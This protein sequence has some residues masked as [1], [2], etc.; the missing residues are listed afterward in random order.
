[1]ETD[2]AIETTETTSRQPRTGPVS[3]ILRLLAAVLMAWLTVEWAT[4]GANGF[5][6]PSTLRNPWF[7]AIT[8]L[9]VYYGLYQTLRVGFGR[10][11]GIRAVTA[12]AAVLVA[13]AAVAIIQEGA[14]WAAPVTWLLYGF[15]VGFLVLVV[16]AYVAS[17]VLGTPGCEMG[18]L[19]ELIVRLR[20]T[21]DT[22]HVEPMWCI[23]GLHRFDEWEARRH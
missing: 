21:S 6:Q 7:W 9:A 3:R 17:T 11:W 14:L 18:A 1:M 23:I 19:G 4:Y 10:R 22:E 20:G 15:D 12:F 2:A 5:T 16:L 13:A 8:G